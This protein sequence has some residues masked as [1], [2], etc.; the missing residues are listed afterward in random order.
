MIEERQEI[1]DKYQLVVG[2]EVHA[3]LKTESKAYSGDINQY[4]SLPNSN[5]S[6]LTLGHPGTLPR[7]NKK[8]VQF[9]IKLGLA[10]NCELTREMHFARKNYFYADLPKGYQITQDTTPIC[11]GGHIDVKGTD[12]TEKRIGITRIHM[13]E[14]AGKSI[15]DQ[16]PFNTLVDLNRAGVPLLEIV[17]EPDIRSS[18]EAYNYLAEIRRLV[19]YLDVCDGNMEEGSMRCDAN[20]SVMLKGS[21][22]FGNRCEVK[23]MNSLRN[24]QRAIEYEMKRQIRILEEG[25]VIE[26]QTR[27]FDAVNGTTF[28]LRGK[29]DAHDYRYFPEPDLQPV[30]LTQQEIDTVKSKMPPLPK[31]LYHKYTKE[32]NLSDYDANIIIDSKPIALFYEAIIAHTKNYKAAANWL[33]GDIKSYVNQNA[34]HID[35]FPVKPENIAQ[36]ISLIDEDLISNSIA[37]EQVFPKMILNPDRSPKEIAESDNLLQKSDDTWLRD[38]AQQAL[39]KYPEKV[40]AYKQGN[41][42]LLGLFMGEVMKLSERKAN[43]KMA[44]QL[45]KE[46]L[47]E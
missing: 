13:E 43:P 8:V 31:E 6:P 45:I 41:K 44:S 16:D 40:E 14:D 46:L 4:G 1:L 7:L 42:G 34:V 5:T 35:E 2:L 26:Q 36:L 29:E 19:R 27:S 18:E 24:V 37:A 12:G 28:K 38:L 21:D 10:T 32:L 30:T 33:M 25:G 39:S 23:N 47:E 17:S 20:V 3:Q 9:A 22:N 11:V 15:H